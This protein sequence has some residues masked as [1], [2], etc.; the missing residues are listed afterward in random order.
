MNKKIGALFFVL[1][2]IILIGGFFGI[3]FVKNKERNEIIEEYT[4]EEEI[5]EN[6]VRQTIVSLYFLSKDS[7]NLVPVARLIDI[8]E[9]INDPC[10]KLVN[11]LIQGP[12]SEKNEGLMPENTKLNKTYYDGDCVVIDLSSEVLNY[13]KTDEHSKNNLVNSIVNTLTQLTEV[14]KVKILVDG[15]ENEEF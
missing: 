7:K 5:A 11:L 10:D 8:K 3:R 6:Q 15:N 2:A 1:L 9:I 12:K 13:D 14:N 4:P